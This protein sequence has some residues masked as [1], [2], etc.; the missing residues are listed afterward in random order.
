[1][2]HLV[3]SDRG[4]VTINKL[5]RKFL[6]SP[7]EKARRTGK[8]KYNPVHGTSPLRTEAKAKETFSAAQVAALLERADSDWQGAILFAYGSGA[9]LGDV[10]N[11]RWSSLD[12]ENE[13]VVFCEQKTGNNHRSLRKVEL[14][15]SGRWQGVLPSEGSDCVV[16]VCL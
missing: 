9:R 15:A 10:A 4:S 7:F 14:H 8:I 16:M 2:S 12:L 3:K 6:S 5:V 11:L 1:V 13:I